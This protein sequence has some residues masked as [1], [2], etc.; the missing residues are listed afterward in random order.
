YPWLR[1]IAWERLA[2]LH[3]RHLHA[4]KRA[5]SREALWDGSLPDESGVALADRLLASGSSPS[6]QVLRLEMQGRVQEAL[7]RLTEPEREVLVMRYL[8]QL[9]IFEIAAV[10]G[11]SES[12][13]KS[14]HLRALQKMRRLLSS[15]QRESEP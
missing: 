4:Q 14:R 12:G 10:L 1:Q 7:A 5:A 11:I 13:V 15:Y 9:S 3:E 2:K 6:K 8:E